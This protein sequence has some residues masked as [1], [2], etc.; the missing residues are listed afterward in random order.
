LFALEVF[1]ENK[2]MIFAKPTKYGAGV[3]LHGD[4]L[5]FNNLH[6]TIHKLCDQIPLQKGLG[7]FVLGLAYDVRHAYQG[8]RDILELADGIV[9]KSTYF[10]FP[11]LWPIF[12][13]QIGLLRWAAGFQ[14]TS[15][16]SQSNLFRLEACAESALTAY[17]PFIG[18]R[19][20][21]WLMSFSGLP[22][23]YL[24]QHIT[25]CSRQYIASQAKGKERFKTLPD[26]L[27]MLS[28]MSKAYWKLEEEL[29][30]IAKEEG[31][32]PDDLSSTEELPDF[33]W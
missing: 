3:I 12:L 19:C 29:K 7:E 27:S 17:D 20:F 14:S 8:D 23:N 6:E 22:D 33:K 30:R 15:R 16:E 24:I 2:E 1:S 9:G 31:C 28:P 10:S 25:D 21:Q 32:A 11:V 13:T 4:Y 18:N 26:I 5:D